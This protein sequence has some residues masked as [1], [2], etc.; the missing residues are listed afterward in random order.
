MFDQQ[1]DDTADADLFF[2]REALKPI[3][4]LVGALDLPGHAQICH[5]M[6]N[7]SRVIPR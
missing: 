2:V 1:F 3:C 5:V 7:A 4:K 6:N